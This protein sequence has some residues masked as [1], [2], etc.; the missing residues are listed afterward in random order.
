[1][2]RARRPGAFSVQFEPYR[3]GRAAGAVLSL[4]GVRP[5][6]EHVDGGVLTVCA[7]QVIDAVIDRHAR[8]VRRAL[9]RG[10]RRIRS[11]RRRREILN[12]WRSAEVTAFQRSR[13]RQ[14]KRRTVN[15][16]FNCRGGRPSLTDRPRSRQGLK[17]GKSM[18]AVAGTF[19]AT[20]SDVK[21][22]TCTTSDGKTIVASHGTTGVATGATAGDADPAVGALDVH[23]VSTRRMTWRGGGK[24]R[25]TSRP[26]RTG[27]ALRRGTPRASRGLA[28]GH[29]MIRACR[30][31]PIC[32]RTSVPR[33]SR[34]ASSAAVPPAALP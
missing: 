11:A 7:S 26:A 21:T 8:T 10:R 17:G 2:P 30:C 3:K 14:S 1:M 34:T 6:D 19:A 24:R 20:P 29:A 4:A 5:D 22:K 12:G 32:P 23:S 18:K 31:S 13:D 15:A 25:S 9:S 27:P 28:R 33:A 16:S